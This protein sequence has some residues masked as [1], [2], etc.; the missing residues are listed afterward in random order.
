[1]AADTSGP[2][3]GSD[4]PEPHA[5][6]EPVTDA[7]SVAEPGPHAEAVAQPQSDPD[8]F[9]DASPCRAARKL[10]RRPRQTSLKKSRILLMSRCCRSATAG[11]GSWLAAAASSPA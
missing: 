8:S 10:R 5:I 9:A 6:A 4:H 7:D 1:V 3:D 11:A 2:H